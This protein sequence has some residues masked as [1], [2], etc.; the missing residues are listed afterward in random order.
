MKKVALS[1]LACKSGNPSLAHR[2]RPLILGALKGL[3][4]PFPRLLLLFSFNCRPSYMLQF[5]S[6]WVKWYSLK[7]HVSQAHVSS[8]CNCHMQKEGLDLLYTPFSLTEM[9]WEGVC[10]PHCGLRVYLAMNYFCTAGYIALSWG[11]FQLGN[12]YRRRS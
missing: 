4:R 9:T 6:G 2:S 12:W 7:F 3:C 5:S 1:W 10:L 11:L 8:N